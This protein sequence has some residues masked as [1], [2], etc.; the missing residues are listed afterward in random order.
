MKAM[1]LSFVCI[2]LHSK[3]VK[4][5]TTK[6]W[7]LIVY[8]RRVICCCSERTYHIRTIGRDRLLF[9]TDFACSENAEMKKKL[10]DDKEFEWDREIGID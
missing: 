5:W 3:V 6:K 10:I 9:Q 2:F 1:F 4:L 8:S 7:R